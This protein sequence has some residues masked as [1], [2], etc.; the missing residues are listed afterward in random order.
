MGCTDIFESGPIKL[1]GSQLSHGPQSSLL[2]EAGL[3]L[4][5]S[6]QVSFSHD[7]LRSLRAVEVK[8]YFVI[9]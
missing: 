4:A 3:A 2:T 9:Y 8:L 5:Y 6:V 1:G 7:E